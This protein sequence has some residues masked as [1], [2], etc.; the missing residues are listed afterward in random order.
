[1]TGEPG[2]VRAVPR[3]PRIHRTD[4]RAL[5]SHGHD[6]VVPRRDY[7]GLVRDDAET[8]YIRSCCELRDEDV[9]GSR[10]RPSIRRAPAWLD[11]LI[12]RDVVPTCRD[13]HS[14]FPRASSGRRRR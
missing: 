11:V 8:A 13:I 14:H 4:S 2:E 1:V 10:T 5:A 12:R 7:L 3:Q 6:V 9:A